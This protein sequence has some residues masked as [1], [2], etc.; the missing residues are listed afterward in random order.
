M[1]V[2]SESG[3]AA[4]NMELNLQEGKIFQI[5]K[6]TNARELLQLQEKVRGKY[7]QRSKESEDAKR[8]K[9]VLQKQ[10]V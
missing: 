6:V 5:Y 8:G 9:P 3:L 7:K 1:S 2:H 10:N 4:E